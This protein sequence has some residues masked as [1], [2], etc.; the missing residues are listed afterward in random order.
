M[1]DGLYLNLYAARFKARKHLHVIQLNTG[2][3]ATERTLYHRATW[4]MSYVHIVGYTSTA[5]QSEYLVL[6]FAL[7]KKQ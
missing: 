7:E 2:P 6:K 1:F 4:Y 3:P 5:I